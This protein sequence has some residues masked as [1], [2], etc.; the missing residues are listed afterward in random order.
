MGKAS[1][2]LLLPL[3]HGAKSAIL[4]H[5]LWLKK[6]N[7]QNN[8]VRD[9]NESAVDPTEDWNNTTEHK[10]SNWIV[11]QMALRN[12]VPKNTHI[13]HMDAGTGA[14]A[15]VFRGTFKYVNVV[16]QNA[17]SAA[18]LFQTYKRACPVKC[19]STSIP[20]PAITATI[21]TI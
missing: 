6:Q 15:I 1:Q 10:I 2:Q 3:I 4:G 11:K 16:E 19:L 13:T 9:W 18:K 14:Q 17:D 21:R 12:K 8:T 20:F 5:K 7:R